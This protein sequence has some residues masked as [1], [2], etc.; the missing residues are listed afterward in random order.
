ME[1]NN[2]LNN[3]STIFTITPKGLTV[4]DTDGTGIS[5]ITADTSGV[6]YLGATQ[7]GIELNADENINMY[8]AGLG[9]NLIA[10]GGT[11]GINIESVQDISL[12]SDEINLTAT[13]GSGNDINISATGSNSIYIESAKQLGLVGTSGSYFSDSTSIELDSTNIQVALNTQ[14]VS[15]P[16]SGVTINNRNGAVLCEGF[17][18]ASG[19]SQTFTVTNSFISVIGNAILCTVTNLGTN[20]AQMVL[21]G[22]QQSTG[23]MDITVINNGTQALNG[24][25]IITFWVVS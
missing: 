1:V 12:Q 11:S 6:L 25:M 10:T 14:I 7:S 18:T 13:G 5:L 15:S 24:N 20:D 16:T 17:T 8:A 2:S 9:F 19:S 23:S 22:I 21:N 3:Q 4:N